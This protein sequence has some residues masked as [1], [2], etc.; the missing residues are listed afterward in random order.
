MADLSFGFQLIRELPPTPNIFSVIRG[1]DIRIEGGGGAYIPIELGIKYYLSEKRFRPLLGLG[2]GTVLARSTFT[3]ATGNIVDGIVRTDIEAEARV[4]IFRLNTGFDYRASLGTILSV[5]ATQY[6][7]QAFEIPI[8]RNPNYEGLAIQV[9]FS[10]F[11]QGH[12]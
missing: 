9:G 5:Y 4:G 7:S 2:V 12:K 8:G 10:V 6:F 3:Q 11:L 1:E